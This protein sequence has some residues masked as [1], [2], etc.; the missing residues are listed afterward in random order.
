MRNLEDFAGIA[1]DWFWETDADHRFTYFSARMEEVT[2]MR[3]QDILGHRRDEQRLICQNESDF[4]AHLDDLRNRR[5]FRN[6]E[7]RIKRQISSGFLWLRVS[8]NPIFDDDGTFRGY[9]GT[10][11]DITAEKETLDRLSQSNAALSARNDEL[12]RLRRQLELA[13][14]EDPLTGL[15][16]RRAF[17][18]SLA[19]VL[20]K[21]DPHLTLMIIDLDRFKQVN[22]TLGHPA[23][24]M[25]LV[26]A[27]GR[28]ADLCDSDSKVFRIG[29]DEFA[30]LRIGCIDPT[31]AVQLGNAIVRDVSVPIRLKDQDVDIGASVGFALSKGIPTSA[32]RLF[33]QA[34]A[35]LYNAKRNGRNRVAFGEA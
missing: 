35:A 17:D 31:Q 4:T 3:P 19:D 7:Y 22:D 6:L 9:R 5:P 20:T 24:D 12:Q 21:S 1:S 26:T 8:G 27:A 2:H 16:N 13:A 25:V 33:A 14:F 10:G 15:P 18:G 11:H 32:Q 23:G 34:D 28:I 29:G 30:V